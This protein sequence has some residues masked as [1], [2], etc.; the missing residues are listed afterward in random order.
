[1]RI[2]RQS[3]YARRG[4][5]R[6][7]EMTARLTKAKLVAGQTTVADYL[8][9]RPIRPNSMRFS[10]AIDLA[11][12]TGCRLHIV[13][14]SGGRGVALIAEARAK[15]VDVTCETCPHYLVLRDTD[16]ERHWRHCEMRA[17]SSFG[18]GDRRDLWNRL[19]TS[20]PSVP[21]TRLRPA[22]NE[23]TIRISSKS[24][25]GFPVVSICCR[26]S[27]PKRS[28]TK[29]CTNKSRPG[30][31]TTSPQRFRVRRKGGIVIGKDADLTLVDPANG[32][33][34][35]A[36]TLRYRHRQSPYLGRKL[37]CRIVRTILRGQT[38]F[39]RGKIIAEVKGQL[40]RPD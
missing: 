9:S 17:A 39:D 21:I 12:E 1:M 24:G 18:R 15:G 6:I 7:E 40:V 27:T 5:C 29:F 4:S 25:A 26:W 14:V 31:A 28:G 22:A 13:H 37:R 23:G 20:R 11:H 35:S 16:M 34:I 32:D 2:A 8:E 38:I 3:R 19:P 36:E 30:R 33:M 10:C